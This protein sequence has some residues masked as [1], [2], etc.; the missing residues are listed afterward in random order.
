MSNPE[1]LYC[2]L[3]ELCSQNPAF[4]FRDYQASESSIYRIFNYRL[5]TYS[6]FLAPG[7][8]EARGSMFEVS[9]SGELIRIASRPPKK[10]FNYGENP[11]TLNLDLSEPALVMK[12]EDGSLMSTYI[13]CDGQ[14]KLKSK[15]AVSSSQCIDAMNHLETLPALARDLAYLTSRG[16]TVN[17]EWTAPWNRVVVGYGAPGL[18]GLS[19]IDNETG[20]VYGIDFAEYTECTSLADHWVK[21]FEY[22][23]YLLSVVKNLVG[24]EGVVCVTASGVTCKIKSDW[25]LHLHRTKDSL[26]N[27]KSLVSLVLSE[28]LDD[29]RSIVAGD[30]T[31]E[32]KLNFFEATVS[33]T[34]NELMQ[35]VDDFHSANAGMGRKEYAMAA[36]EYWGDDSTSTG[37]NAQMFKMAGRDYEEMIKAQLVK[38]SGDFSDMYE[39]YLQLESTTYMH[40]SIKNISIDNYIR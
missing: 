31:S 24:E 8:F 33:K 39:Y 22:D 38:R 11:L 9:N 4:Y 18:T 37:F 32:T 25:Y 20:T 2:Q 26:D 35:R 7:A 10:F 5:S 3:I 15:G 14:L 29:L 23:G 16:F 1:F 21:D 19:V 13:H 30:I 36:K 27:A 28:Q 34:F 40:L 17:L 12:K 6:D